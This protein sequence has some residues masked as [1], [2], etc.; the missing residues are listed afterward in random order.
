MAEMLDYASG[1]TSLTGGQGAFHMEFS[2][3]DEVPTQ[4]RER[5]IAEVKSTEKAES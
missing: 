1:L 3:Y 5:V 4:V 2:H